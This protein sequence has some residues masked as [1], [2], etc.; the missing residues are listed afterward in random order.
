M[1]ISIVA[2]VAMTLNVVC[3][4]QVHAQ[5]APSR[6][7]A[8]MQAGIG[9][10]R[11]GAF[12]Q[13]LRDFLDARRDGL[14]TPVLHYNL[15][16]TYYKLGRDKEAAAEFTSLLPDPKF[17]EFARYNL[18]LIARRTG[19][20]SE[21]R[22]YFSAVASDGR[23][24]HLQALARAELHERPAGFSAW[25]KPAWQG[26]LEVGGG[27]DDNVAL[28]SR[29]ALLTPSGGGSPAISAL[30]SGGGQLTGNRNRG[31]RLVGS[32]Y[33]TQYPNR[34]AFDLLIARAGPEY[35]FAVASWR[36]QTG[37][38][39]THIRLGSNELETLGVLN[40]R[41][42]HA[43]G[44]GRLRLD[45]TVERIGGGARYGYLTGWQSRYGVRTSWSP[46][47][48]LI[49]LGYGLTRNRRQ[50]LA[51]G[52]QF[53]SVS[54]TRNQV[55]ADLRWNTTL[56]TALYVRGT[57]WRSRYADPNVFLQGGALVTQRRID[58][59]H[60]AEVGLLYRLSSNARITAE[61]GFRRNDSNIARYAY[62]SNRYML[63]FQYGF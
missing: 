50:D 4:A 62:S 23:N 12:A 43:L 17:G 1:R 48:F 20:K 60:D 2:A 29:S 51:F 15:G 46:G 33:D 44:S 39:A 57:Y 27:Y 22:E 24:S 9:E 31:L 54:P 45:Y 26:L 52:N 40:L 19:R 47:P 34:S 6:A 28:V 11:T 53:S 63:K 10:F 36:I 7:S 37:G 8:A 13:A 30:A 5:A 58:D 56:R 42:E 18:G 32:L 61:Y 16:A 25:H 38:Y 59:G 3:A 49:T 21:A 41:G 35:R 55:D 14:D